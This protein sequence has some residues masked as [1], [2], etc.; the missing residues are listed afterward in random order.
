M[1]TVRIV[2]GNS[3]V[4]HDPDDLRHCEPDV[5]GGGP[6]SSAG[7]SRQIA[8]GHAWTERAQ[9]FPSLGIRNQADFANFIK[10]VIDNPSKVKK[11][12]KGRF[13]FWDSGTDTIIF[14]DPN[15]PDLGTAFRPSRG[16]DYFNQ[17]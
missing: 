2:L 15:N 5:W 4:G 3:A 1:Q 10:T 17:Q 11:L 12:T 14:Y 16:I 13:A 9:E 7:V 8:G 6:F